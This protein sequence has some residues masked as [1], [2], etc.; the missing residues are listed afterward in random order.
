M[1]LQEIKSELLEKGDFEFFTKI[2]FSQNTHIIAQN[3]KYTINVHLKDLLEHNQAYLTADL[4]EQ[5]SDIE[6]KALRQLYDARR[7]KISKLRK[8]LKA[9]IKVTPFVYFLTLTWR[10][11]VLDSTIQKTRRT[12]VQRFLS[13]HNFIDYHANIDFGTSTEREHY[14]AL[15]ALKEDTLFEWSYGFYKYEPV[16]ITSESI[17]KLAKYVNKLTYHAYKDSTRNERAITPKQTFYPYNDFQVKMHGILKNRLQP[18][19]DT[20]VFCETE[21]VDY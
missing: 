5:F 3:P 12:Y 19:S 13:S 1:Q 4:N 17:S 18:T 15:I 10:D 9:M 14:H 6:L 7:S 8:K 21:R 2:L 16:T 20:A 11:D